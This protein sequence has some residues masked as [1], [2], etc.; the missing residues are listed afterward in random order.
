MPSRA[1][2]MPAP[3]LCQPVPSHPSLA[4]VADKAS[5]DN[6]DVAKPISWDQAGHQPSWEPE[7]PIS[8]PSS[9]WEE[10]CP[11]PQVKGR[12]GWLWNPFS[13]GRRLQGPCRASMGHHGGW[14]ASPKEC[15]GRRGDQ[16]LGRRG[17]QPRALETCL[18]PLSFL[19]GAQPGGGLRGLPAL[20][21]HP[22]A[23]DP[24]PPKRPMLLWNV[25]FAGHTLLITGWLPHGHALQP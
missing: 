21:P 25:Q 24:V 16:G 12:Q 1:A 10:A 17:F 2:Q 4:S 11:R 14:E 22:C 8:G 7:G 15:W 19:V 13:Q 23:Q 5:W 20:Q 18:Q 9:A 6:I 3:R